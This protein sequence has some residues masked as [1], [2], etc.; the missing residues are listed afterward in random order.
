[1]S[2]LPARPFPPRPARALRFAQ[3]DSSAHKMTLLAQGDSFPLGLCQPVNFG[4]PEQ[5][6]G[7]TDAL[8]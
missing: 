3:G 5:V 8:V 6:H 1:M 7:T 2:A 4:A